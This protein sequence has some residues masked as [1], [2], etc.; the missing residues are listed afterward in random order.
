MGSIRDEKVL[1]QRGQGECQWEEG[2]DQDSLFFTLKKRGGVVE[3][4]LGV[5]GSGECVR[6]EGSWG[7]GK[8]GVF[9]AVGGE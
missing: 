3:I 6:S 1:G 4:L 2:K 9:E 5:V 7:G 8:G